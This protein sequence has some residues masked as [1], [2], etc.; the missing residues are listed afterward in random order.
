[1]GVKLRP[2]IVTFI[3]CDFYLL[4]HGDCDIYIAIFES[5]ISTRKDLTG[6]YCSN[7]QIQGIW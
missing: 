5:E 2:Q 6:G 3:K 7:K 4:V 1:M